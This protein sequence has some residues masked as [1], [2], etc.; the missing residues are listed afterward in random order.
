MALESLTGGSVFIDDLV[1]TNPVNA[2]D[3]VAE[4]DDHIRGIKNVLLN[5]FPAVTGAVTSTHT[6]LNILDGV[7]ASAGDINAITNFEET[8]SATTSEVTIATSKTLNVTDNSGFKL[9]GTAV[10][11]TAAELNYLDLATLGTGAASKAVVLDSGD[12]YTWPATGILTYGVL[13]DGTTALTAT[14]LEINTVCDGVLTGSTTWNPGSITDQTELGINI[15]V[16]GAAVGDFVIV[17]PGVSTQDMT[18][19]GCVSAPNTVRVTLSNQT[20]GPIDLA[21]ST[22]KVKVLK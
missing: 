10:S 20:G 2:T 8:V 18:F 16:N 15:T 12:D 5:S 9:A 19:S 13:N 7:T 11:S 14:A 17:A 22:W 6:E 21:S 3:D 1:N 4:G